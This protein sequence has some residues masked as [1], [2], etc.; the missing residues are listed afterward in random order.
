MELWSREKNRGASEERREYGSNQ[1]SLGT[2][3][4]QKNILKQ[5]IA[6][7]F[8]SSRQKLVDTLRECILNAFFISFKISRFKIVPLIVGTLV[9]SCPI[10]V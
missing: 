9:V 5:P 10:D 3:S 6:D 8:L 7:G 4:E 1:A 2:A